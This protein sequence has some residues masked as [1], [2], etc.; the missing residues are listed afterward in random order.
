VEREGVQPMRGH[1]TLYQVRCNFGRPIKLLTVEAFPMNGLSDAKAELNLRPNVRATE[2]LRVVFDEPTG[3]T[4]S[5]APASSLLAMRMASSRRW[6]AKIAAATASLGTTP[7]VLQAE[8]QV[9]RRH[10]NNISGRKN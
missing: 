6:T 4:V 8:V 9:V 10:S 3:P 1:I 2:R 7:T 5:C